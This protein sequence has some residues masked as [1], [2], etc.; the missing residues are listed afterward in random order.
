[1]MLTTHLIATTSWKRPALSRLASIGLLVLLPVTASAQSVSLPL[2]SQ[3][4][5]PPI[6]AQPVQTPSVV[7]TPPQQPHQAK[8]QKVSDAL[9]IPA[10]DVR[11]LADRTVTLPFL[12]LKL[13]LYKILDE[14][15]G[16]SHHLALDSTG[17]QVD[18]EALQQEERA[19][20]YQQ[21]GNMQVALHD[22]V[23]RGDQSTIPV[24]IKLN[25]A[26]QE[27]DKESA[28]ADTLGEENTVFSRALI[29][30]V[31]RQ[32]LKATEVLR[33]A[34]ER[35]KH[36]IP[37]AVAES[38]PFVITMLSPAAIRALSRDPD[39]AFIGIHDEQEIP[40]YPTIAE[41][42][43]TTRTNTVH[44]Y[45][46]KGAGVKIAVLEGGTTTKPTACFNIGA[47]QDA[48]AGSND[49]MTKSVAIIG[50]R[51]NGGAC[52]GSWEGYA[53]S[54]TVLIANKG[55]YV[56]RYNWA[57][58]KGVNVITMSWH[59]PSEETDGDLHSR[60]IYFDYVTTHYPWPTVFTSAGNQASSGA[61]ASG[62]GYNFFGVGNVENDGDGNRCN[63]V[64]ASSSS[65]EDPT[66]PHNDREIPEIAS[67][68]SRHDLIGSSFGGTSAATPVTAAI[69]SLLMSKNTSLKIWPEAIR[70]ILLASANY[71]KGDG[72]NWSKFADGKDGT[73]MTNTYFAY[74]TAN[75]RETSTTAQFRAHD[76]GTMTKAKINGAFFEK[77]WK[78][79]TFTT[80]GRIRVAL[81]WNSKTT[82]TSSVLDADL[83]LWVYD[84][85]MRLVATSTTWDSSYEFVEFTPRKTGQYTIKV[86]GYSV[87]NNFSSY[88]GVAWT[89]HY[90]LCQ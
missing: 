76:Y 25:V 18:Y 50:N 69:A 57:K 90:D 7:E 56:E 61:Y 81:T 62:K 54:A 60:D 79:K 72:T 42:L 8:V 48:G 33:T 59:Y 40:D 10:T 39:V 14:K 15:T 55:D 1:M 82:R 13:E 85:D 12:G 47:I 21:Y 2:A 36:Q 65:W 20:R 77:T 63:D 38:G 34:F 67:P 52:N 5:Q 88:Y 78:A 58:T 24:L 31:L 87:P 51:Y 68:G 46:T 37:E 35:I 84:P 89:T 27:V 64:I 32:P 4:I 22:L 11:L 41:S 28:S 86:R 74:H 49:H 44:S 30:P 66:T 3:S 9:R 26:E 6:V 71:Q 53:P 70:A 73:G 16:D 23:A 43:P 17:A 19:L 75:K 45:G 80:N 83:D 29:S